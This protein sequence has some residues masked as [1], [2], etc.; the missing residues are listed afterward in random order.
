MEYRYWLPFKVIFETYL[1]A[2]YDLGTISL[3]PQELKLISFRHGLGLELD[4]DTP[5]GTGAFGLGKSFYF[6]KDLPTTPV[7]VGPLVF[8]FSVGHAL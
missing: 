4:L 6:R 7:T 1:K 2:R 5:L 8:Y 3:E